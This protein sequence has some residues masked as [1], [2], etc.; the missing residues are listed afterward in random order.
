MEYT[1]GSGLGIAC[2]TLRMLV[3]HE[4]DIQVFRNVHSD[5]YL[6]R[7][8]VNKVIFIYNGEQAVAVINNVRATVGLTGKVSILLI[9]LKYLQ[10]QSY[11]IDN[12][13][14]EKP[15]HGHS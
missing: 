3:S 2:N 11:N 9:A 7:D 14:E 8:A 5:S 10:R 12:V 1:T 13:E 6:Q 4:N 15:S